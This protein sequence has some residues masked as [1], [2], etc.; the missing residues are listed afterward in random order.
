MGGGIRAV[1]FGVAMIVIGAVY[2]KPVIIIGS[3]LLVTITT[4]LYVVGRR[5]RWF[6]PWK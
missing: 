3:V 6:D 2:G 1:L 5:R 4:V